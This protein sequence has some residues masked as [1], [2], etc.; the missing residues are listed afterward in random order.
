MEKAELKFRVSLYLDG[1]VE[2]NGYENEPIFIR[3]TKVLPENE[4]PKGCFIVEEVFD[5]VFWSELSDRIHS[6]RYEGWNNGDF[7]LA[8]NIHPLKKNKVD[9]FYT[10]IISIN[11]SIHAK[12]KH[13]YGEQFN[14]K[15]TFFI[16]E[17]TL[18][19]DMQTIY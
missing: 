6:T 16:C 11:N 9:L 12:C 5:G 17:N 7:C 1:Y 4:I 10:E 8:W 2:K 13:Y 15:K 19:T 14:V 3:E 18:F